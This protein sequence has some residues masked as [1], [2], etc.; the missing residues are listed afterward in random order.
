MKWKFMVEFVKKHK[1]KENL[2]KKWNATFQIDV[3]FVI[4][5]FQSS[6]LALLQ[7]AEFKI[8]K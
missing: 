2:I 5:S 6:I 4:T 3:Y 1:T 7:L 8:K